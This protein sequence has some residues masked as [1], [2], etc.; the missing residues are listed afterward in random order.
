MAAPD[1]VNVTS[2]FGKTTVGELTT[3][4]TDILT[5]AAASNKVYKVNTVLVSN[6]DGT[7]PADVTIALRRSSVD[8]KLAN[9]ITV[10]AD[11]SLVALSKESTI[12]MEEGDALRFTASADS[13][14]Q[15]VIS[16]EIIDDA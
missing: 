12:Y 6:I 14:L 9:T 11:A 2:I 7:N 5:N 16:Y 13:D 4:P 3:T 15:T 8:Y 10:P 1:I